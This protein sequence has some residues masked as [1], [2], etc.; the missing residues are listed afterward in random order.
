LHFRF[1]ARAIEVKIPIGTSIHAGFSVI[2]A[3]WRWTAGGR[4]TKSAVST[5]FQPRVESRSPGIAGHPRGGLVFVGELNER[6]ASSELIEWRLTD[7]RKSTLS[8]FLQAGC[9]S[10]SGT[11][12]K[13]NL[14][15][16]SSARRHRLLLTC[17]LGTHNRN[18]E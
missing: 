5:F 10:R 4:F 12:Q 3:P 9:V 11:N 8:C 6:L 13:T 14:R 18:S 16:T 1:E 7:M 15:K 2:R 17:R